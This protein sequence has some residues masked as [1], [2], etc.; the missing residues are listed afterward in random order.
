MTYTI[1]RTDG[2]DLVTIPDQTIDTATLGTISLVGK[3]AVHYGTAFAENF[4]YMLENFSSPEAPVNPLRGQLWYDS[5][6][7]VLKVFNGSIWRNVADQDGTAV[8]SPNTLVRRDADGNFSATTISASLQGNAETAD[9]LRTPRVIALTGDVEG[10]AS[11]DGSNDVSIDVRLVGG[12]TFSRMAVSAED[13]EQSS[14]TS[15]DE[16][17]AL[18]N[19]ALAETDHFLMADY[20]I[21]AKDLKKIKSYRQSLRDITK[22]YSSLE[23]VV[24]PE[25]PDLG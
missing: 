20:P 21:S 17:R 23:D 10:T 13:V 1:K 5:G 22:T 11:F 24:W 14:A 6:D 16:L 4:V 12:T 8:A 15:G 25:Y 7:S 3:G 18:R 19:Q 2:T 9:K